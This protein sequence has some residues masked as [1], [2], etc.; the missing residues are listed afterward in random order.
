MTIKDELISLKNTIDYVLERKIIDWYDV[1]TI[2]KGCVN[3]RD[4][5]DNIFNGNTI[6]L[7]V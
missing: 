4:E 6:D 2:R 1:V 5:I 3:V 7:S